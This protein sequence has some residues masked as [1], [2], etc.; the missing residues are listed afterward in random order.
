MENMDDNV[1]RRLRE[2]GENLKEAE[3]LRHEKISNLA[4]LT[5]LYHAMIYSLFALLGI[6]EI[7]NLTH[8][9][10]IE[11]FEREFVNN[12]IFKREYLDAMRF[13]Y[14][15]TH[16]C[17]CAM[18]KEPEDRDIDYLFPVSADFVRFAGNYLEGHTM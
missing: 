8:A 5:K 2:A 12:G 14:N 15:F 13:A 18:M 4:T 16:E 3:L 6:K 10:L 7:G 17:D 1:D 9:D 11:R